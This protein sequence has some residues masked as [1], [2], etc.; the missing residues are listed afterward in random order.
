MATFRDVDSGQG[1]GEAL[2]WRQIILLAVLGFASTFST[3]VVFPNIGS[4]VRDRFILSDTASS[5]FAVSY[6]LPHVIFA[7]VWGAASDRRGSRKP[8]LVAGYISTALFHVLLPFAPTY[9]TLLVLRFLEGSTSILGFSMVMTI[10]ADYARRTS[11]GKVMGLMGGAVSLGTTLAFPLGGAIGADSMVLLCS[12]GSIIL[13]ACAVTATVL[14]RETPNAQARSFGDALAV[15]RD[16]PALL[17]PYFFTFIDRFT[18]GFFA[19]TFPLYVS[20]AY[21]MNAAEAGRILAG[22]LLPFSLL[23]YVFG[24]LVDR[25]G[26]LYM[27]L[28]GSFLYGVLV[29]FTGHVGKDT[30]TLFMVLCGILAASMYAPSLWLVARTAPPER[31]ASAMGGF[32]AIGSIGFS[33]G[34][35]AGGLM[36]DNFGYTEAFYLAGASE[37][38]CVLIAIPLL[39]HALKGRWKQ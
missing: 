12:M 38:L 15:V 17:T 10:A 25:I 6:L 23:T 28:T 34:P 1:L 13:L 39:H 37:I 19:V 18:V 7:F 9:E 27:L 5:L 8:F 2:P 26:G 30:L 24:R 3:A 35:L 20:Y 16:N 36:A 21:G 22:F 31:R 14:L 33:L 4:F 29:L 32:N 11:T